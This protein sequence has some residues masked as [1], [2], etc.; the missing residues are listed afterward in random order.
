MSNVR[1]SIDL[2]AAPTILHHAYLRISHND[3]FWLIQ[4]PQTNSLSESLV[5]HLFPSEN[6]TYKFLE[7]IQMSAPQVFDYAFAG[8]TDNKVGVRYS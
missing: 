8:H 5:G 2:W 7:T 6:V 4:I 3:L 1:S